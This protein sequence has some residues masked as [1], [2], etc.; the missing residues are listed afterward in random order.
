MK[1]FEKILSPIIFDWVKARTLNL[2]PMDQIVLVG[3]VLSGCN[4]VCGYCRKS[5]GKMPLIDYF[6][7]FVTQM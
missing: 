6:F 5:L 3:T 2:R 1:N 4:P 7:N